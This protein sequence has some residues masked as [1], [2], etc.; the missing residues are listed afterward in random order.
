MTSPHFHPARAYSPHPASSFTHYTPQLSSPRPASP[1]LVRD[2]FPPPRPQHERTRSE[3]SL[4]FLDHS[5]PVYRDLAPAPPT[6]Y[7][8]VAYPPANDDRRLYSPAPTYYPRVANQLQAVHYTQDTSWQRGQSRPAELSYTQQPS[9]RYLQQCE[10]PARQEVALRGRP[11]NVSDIIDK[12]NRS[13]GSIN[14]QQTRTEKCSYQPQQQASTARVVPTVK[15]L[16]LSGVEHFRLDDKQQLTSDRYS[17]RPKE[18]PAQS[19]RTESK[20]SAIPQTPF[21]AKRSMNLSGVYTPLLAR[22]RSRSKE[23]S[24]IKGLTNKLQASHSD[25][26]YR[27]FADRRDGRGRVDAASYTP[28]ETTPVTFRK[29]EAAQTVRP[30][31][32]DQSNRAMQKSPQE[33]GSPEHRQRETGDERLHRA[34]NS[35]LSPRVCYRELNLNPPPADCVSK[36]D[37]SITIEA[38]GEARDRPR[39]SLREKSGEKDRSFEVRQR[40][41]ETRSNPPAKDFVIPNQSIDSNSKVSSPSKYASASQQYDSNFILNMGNFDSVGGSSDD[42]YYGGEDRIKQVEEMPQKETNK[43]TNEVNYSFGVKQH[44]YEAEKECRQ[45]KPK[46][47]LHDMIKRNLGTKTSGEKKNLMKEMDGVKGR[48]MMRAFN[49]SNDTVDSVDTLTLE[50]QFMEVKKL[51]EDDK[52][53]K[54]LEGE[55]MM[56]NASTFTFSKME[57]QMEGLAVAR[58][59][60]DIQKA[61]KKKTG[62]IYKEVNKG[63]EDRFGQSVD[64]LNL[65][66]YEEDSGRKRH[67]PKPEP[68]KPSPTAPSR[69]SDIFELRETVLLRS[70]DDEPIS[71]LL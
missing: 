58:D 65:S 14:E 30:P 41:V 47:I 20:R 8:P 33:E 50:H 68:P 51:T 24:Q 38:P 21:S 9:P 23:A 55:K 61:F 28:I 53:R 1:Y 63:G 35:P 48:P 66:K 67:P 40:E 31:P 34:F 4:S 60:D 11:T 7:K 62:G 57:K 26:N 71:T 6:Q 5:L 56:K 54:M 46:T 3:I 29:Q 52:Y 44:D 10:V 12:F 64:Y 49:K 18:T 15:P 59:G 69:P 45:I 25:A 13:I 22:S 27:M 2:H 37:S 42:L 39:G 17:K 70:I 43:D 19:Q 36:K 32:L 16:V